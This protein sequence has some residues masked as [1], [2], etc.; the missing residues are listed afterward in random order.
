M[1]KKVGADKK[2]G[3]N[4]P[5]IFSFFILQ[6]PLQI[7]QGLLLILKTYAKVTCGINMN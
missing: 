2:K 5:Y 1:E 4:Y 7:L 3:Q 6:A